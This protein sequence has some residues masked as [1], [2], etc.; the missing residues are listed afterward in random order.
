VEYILS[1]ML[2]AGAFAASLAFILLIVMLL[3]FPFEG[4]LRLPSSCFLGTV[5]MDR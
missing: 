3:D 4:V 1:Q 2:F 5:Q